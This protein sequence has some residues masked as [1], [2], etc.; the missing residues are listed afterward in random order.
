V[1][2]VELPAEDETVD[3]IVAFWNPAEPPEPGQE[4]LY[5]YRL[6]WGSATPFRPSL[7]EVLATRDGIGGVV[8]QKRKYFSWRFVI[9]FAG[10]SLPLI[11]KNA[12]VEPVIDASRGTVEIASARPLASTGGYRAM[13]DLKPGDDSPA[14]IDLRLYLRVDGQP[15]SETWMYQWSPP[16]RA[17]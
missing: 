7:A 6:Y 4:L 10:G 5:D 8:G 14:P 1:Q 16:E 11:A 9:D 15:L 17:T 2:L 12:K 13:F 3:N